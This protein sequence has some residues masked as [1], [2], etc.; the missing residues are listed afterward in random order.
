MYSLL[1]CPVE[2]ATRARVRKGTRGHPRVFQAPCLAY[3]KTCS[4]Q[5][6]HL[7]LELQ[8]K[9]RTWVLLLLD[10]V[11]QPRTPH[12]RQWGVTCFSGSKLGFTPCPNSYG[13]HSLVGSDSKEFV[14][15]AGDPGSVPG[16][17]SLTLVFLPKNP[18]DRRA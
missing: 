17:R 4:A 10:D 2:L 14:C 5:L 3:S 9:Y 7:V 12:L 1:L 15:S 18:M 6:L 13:Q 11:P 8:P 16:S